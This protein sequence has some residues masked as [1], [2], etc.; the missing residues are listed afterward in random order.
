MIYL[1][2]LQDAGAT[3]VQPGDRQEWPSFAYDSRLAQAGDLF[4]ALKTERADGHAFINEAI[5]AGASGI[6]CL[7]PPANLPPELTVLV[8]PD[9]LELISRWASN[10][11]RHIAPTVIAVTGSVGKT[12]TKRA[13]TTLLADDGSVFSSPRSFNSTL[14]LAVALSELE[15]RHRWAVLEFGADRRGEID[16]LSRLFPPHIGVVTAVGA[17]HL[18]AFGTL[19]G[20]ARE[21]GALIRAVPTDGW[22][23]LNADD[24]LVRGLTRETPAWVLTYG[25]G[26][27]CD[28][29]F[30][31]VRSSLEGTTFDLHGHSR[32]SARPGSGR[33]SRGPRPRGCRRLT[34]GPRRRR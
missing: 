10:R 6:V 22:A 1:N 4:V 12:S 33:P 20:V 2:E 18:S 19:E 30:S 29:W 28:V 14:G 8:A 34:G 7:H 3:V 21:K 15:A 11:V 16:Q 27:H 32:Q 31:N 23:V 24:P 13:I 5:A 9:V 17:A 25:S 26:P